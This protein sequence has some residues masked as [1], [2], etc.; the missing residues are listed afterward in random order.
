M[1]S[2]P[3][4]VQVIGLTL[5]ASNVTVVPVP[6][7][8]R[9]A[10]WLLGLKYFSPLF[11]WTWR[12]KGPVERAARLQ[13]IQLLWFVGV[14]AYEC[15]DIPYVANLWDLQHRC[16]PFFPEVSAAGMWD[17]REQ[18]YGYFLR[19]AA[20]CITGTETGKREVQS[21]Y[22]LE[23]SRVRTLP[24]PTPTFA[25]GAAPSKVDARSHFKIDKDYVFYP[26]Q[27]WPHKNHAN[28]ILA[29][30]R[31]KEQYGLEIVLALCG[32]DKGNLS[33]IRSFVDR[34]GMTQQVRFLGFVSAE[35][36]I[37]LYRQA[38][39]LTFVTYFGPDNLPPLEAFALGC[40]V[41][42]SAVEGSR[43]QYKD[44]VVYVDPS[45]PES[46]SRAIWNV[47]SDKELRQQ[48]VHSGLRR[49]SEW[50]ATDYVKGMLDLFSEFSAVRRNWL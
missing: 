19:R 40:P 9:P 27:F 36:M 41:I 13:D 23:E 4:T 25:L 24:L 46:I 30:K 2:D 26:A 38:V 5:D 45:D 33:F 42:A 8:S 18:F 34:E 37:A 11:R 49:A 21:L 22:Q 31:L 44:A 17:K 15:P 29:L 10:K 48:L 3:A 32:S 28:L 47:Y 39:A 35:E 12:R 1:F 43:E 14:G 7:L 20:F 6:W 16:Q 50:T